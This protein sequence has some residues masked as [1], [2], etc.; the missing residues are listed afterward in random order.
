MIRSSRKGAFEDGVL[1][2]WSVEGWFVRNVYWS[3]DLLPLFYDLN[4]VSVQIRIIILSL[5]RPNTLDRFLCTKETFP[6]PTTIFT[7]FYYPLYLVT[8]ILDLTAPNKIFLDTS[9]THKTTQ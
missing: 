5:T 4:P 3:R 9:H 8:R 7:Q 1:R 2:G 6:I